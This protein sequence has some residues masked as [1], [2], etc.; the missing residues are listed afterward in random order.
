M[1]LR[2]FHHVYA[3]NPLLVCIIYILPLWN[4]Q[5][6]LPSQR[7]TKKTKND[8]KLNCVTKIVKTYVSHVPMPPPTST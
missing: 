7:K 5:A 3:T 4:T 8:T 1:Y 6:R 2:E